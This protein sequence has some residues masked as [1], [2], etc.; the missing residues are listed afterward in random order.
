MSKTEIISASNYLRHGLRA[1]I[2]AIC[3]T[4][5]ITIPLQA[6]G[7]QPKPFPSL[8]RKSDIRIWDEEY[9]RGYDKKGWIMPDDYHG[10]MGRRII[11]HH[12][13]AGIRDDTRYG[14][15]GLISGRFI[16][17]TWR[18]IYALSNAEYAEGKKTIYDTH[19]SNLIIPSFKIKLNYITF[20]ISG[21]YAP[22]EA[23]L[24][25]L[26]N[27]KVMRSATGRNNDKVQWVAFDVK[28]LIGKSAQIQV[29]D[30]STKPFAHITV[31][32][33]CQS[34]DTKDAVRVIGSAPVITQS[35]SQ[36]ETL[37]KK[38]NGKV[39]IV[40]GQFQLNG[41]TQPLNTI[42]K[43]RAG[44]KATESN[45]KR[46]QLT[47]GDILMGEVLELVDNKLIMN[48][49]LLGEL[50]IS[51]TDVAQ[52]LFNAGPL[53]KA[54]PGTL[55]HSNGNKIPGKITYIRKDNISIKCVLG[56][57]P[58]P[59]GRVKAF[60]F[61]ASEAQLASDSITLIDGSKLSGIVSLGKEQLVLNHS[62]LGKL[63]FTANIIAQLSRQI[64]GLTHL[65][66]LKKEIIKQSGPITPPAPLEIKNK[67]GFVLRLYSNSTV[68]YA[69]P[70]SSIKKYFRGTLAPVANMNN[71]LLA[72]VAFANHKKTYTIEPGSEGI[73]VDIDLGLVSNFE[74]TVNSKNSVSFP[75]ALE[76]RNAYII[77]GVKK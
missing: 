28:D 18:P 33:V 49:P 9:L 29:L 19:V 76:W 51:V 17:S 58:L 54:K 65:S 3:I 24:N 69:V 34:P 30:T 75:S 26:V 5:F 1:P 2:Y 50:K 6:R 67:G 52:A 43:W 25:L 11:Y 72:E 74:L 42:L 14:R 27:G 71:S 32:C 56:Q 40:N 60:I 45:G 12:K 61:S 36:I 8:V 13:G 41:K 23:C 31:D 48:H 39:T 55:V 63:K 16:Y 73:A 10:S 47:N 35:D 20:L 38:V 57:L 46:V 37:A 7:P 64:K 22:N 62:K 15:F 77:E 21:G 4:L 53:L 66:S 70:K 68:R 44:T 59:R